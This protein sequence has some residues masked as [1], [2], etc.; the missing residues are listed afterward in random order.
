MTPGAAMLADSTRRVSYLRRGPDP[1][2][3]RVRR[4]TYTC[5]LLSVI[6]LGASV[7][8]TWTAVDLALQSVSV[9]EL[10]RHSVIGKAA[11]WIRIYRPKR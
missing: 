9:G 3:R 2:T 8:V 1:V 7:A 5:L 11:A 6:L 10:V 4:L